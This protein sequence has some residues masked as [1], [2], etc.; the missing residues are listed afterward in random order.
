MRLI[1]PDRKMLTFPI[2]FLKP[3]QF[4]LSDIKQPCGSNLD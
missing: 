4:F 1:A 2:A 3:P